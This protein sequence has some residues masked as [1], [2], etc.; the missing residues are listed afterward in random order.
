M[1]ILTVLIRI[2]YNKAK[3][4]NMLVLLNCMSHHSLLLA[5]LVRA[6]EGCS[7]TVLGELHI[8]HCGKMTYGSH[9]IKFWEIS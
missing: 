2:P 3:M 7:L 5:M 4:R 9:A 6:D 1:S 8:S